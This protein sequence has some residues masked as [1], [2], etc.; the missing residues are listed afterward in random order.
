M[1]TEKHGKYEYRLEF[2]PVSFQGFRGGYKKNTG[3]QL[4]LS[5]SVIITLKAY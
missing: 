4:N 3:T 1:A 2:F 5:A